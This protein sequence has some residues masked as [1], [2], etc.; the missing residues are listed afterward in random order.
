MCK[1][2]LLIKK[3]QKT[4]FKWSEVVSFSHLPVRHQVPESLFRILGCCSLDLR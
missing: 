4:D 2:E 3:K 1:Q